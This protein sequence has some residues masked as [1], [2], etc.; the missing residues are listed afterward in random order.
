MSGMFN[1]NGDSTTMIGALSSKVF[2]FSQT[3]LNRASSKRPKKQINAQT[4]ANLNKKTT[5]K[6]LN[7]NEFLMGDN[8]GQP[9]GERLAEL[10]A[11]ANAKGTQSTSSMRSLS[12]HQLVDGAETKTK[13]KVF[14]KCASHSKTLNLFIYQG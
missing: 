8:S 6:L 14:S 7:G 4:L 5:N 10:I 2:F 11:A 12:N 9:I 1:K 13:K 3:E